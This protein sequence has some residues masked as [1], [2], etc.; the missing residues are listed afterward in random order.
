MSPL[1]SRGHHTQLRPT[2]LFRGAYYFAALGHSFSQRGLWVHPCQAQEGLLP[3]IAPLRNVR[4]AAETT[5]RA[6]HPTLHSSPIMQF[7]S[8]NEYAVPGTPQKCSSLARKL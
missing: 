8:A 2:A 7:S 4:R 1:D 3:P 6:N 5:A